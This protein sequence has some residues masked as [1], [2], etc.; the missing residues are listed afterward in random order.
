M[1]QIGSG[2]RA[3][4]ALD[5]ILHSPPTAVAA[6]PVR[7]LFPAFALASR[8]TAP[9]SAIA[10]YDTTDFAAYQGAQRSFPLGGTHLEEEMGSVYSAKG[11]G[12]DLVSALRDDTPASCSR[13]PAGEGQGIGA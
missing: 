6:V 13:V 1:R 3:R 5:A 8:A 12:D 2:I 7:A 11:G 10:A 9:D 4:D